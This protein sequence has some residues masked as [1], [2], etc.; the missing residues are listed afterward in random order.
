MNGEAIQERS[1]KSSQDNRWTNKRDKMKD[2]MITEN[3][4]KHSWDNISK[5]NQGER[6]S[7]GNDCQG[8]ISMTSTTK[9]PAQRIS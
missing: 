5:K 2:E 3:S 9:K 6:E 1:K 8:H 7:V 4:E